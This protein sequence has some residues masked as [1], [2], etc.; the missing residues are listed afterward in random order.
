MALARRLWSSQYRGTGVPASRPLRWVPI[1]G[2][3]R[4]LEPS[5][6][7]I[8]PNSRDTCQSGSPTQNK[9]PTTR[10]GLAI[11]LNVEWLRHFVRDECSFVRIVNR[12]MIFYR[13][14]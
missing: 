13:A 8:D 4:C 7:Q 9:W 11:F 5:R 14:G 10:L 2:L 1:L 3:A 6:R 12:Q